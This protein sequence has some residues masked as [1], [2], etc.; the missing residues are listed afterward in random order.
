MQF[1]ALRNPP[2]ATRAEVDFLID[3]LRLPPGARI[4]DVAC[5]HGRHSVELAR[6]GFEV[7]GLDLSTPSLKIA[8]ESAAQAGLD[9]TFVERDMRDI[10]FDSEFDAAINMFTAFG[11]LET[12]EDDQKVLEAIAR[13][14]IEGGLFFIDFVNPLWLFRIYQPRAWVEWEGGTI[15]MED[16]RYDALTGRNIVTLK[17]IRPDGTS[18]ERRHALRLYTP[19]ELRSKLA[20][21]GLL[22]EQSWGGFDGRELGLDSPRTLLLARKN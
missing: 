6:R 2:E 3:A 5:G 14:L 4:L 11:Y 13:A 20:K 21:A 8:R 12:E 16:R 17:L 22:V 10:G 9:V 18:V 1:T 7:T 19:A 15:S